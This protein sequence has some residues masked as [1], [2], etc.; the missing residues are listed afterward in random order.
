[1]TTPTRTW[2]D[3][4]VGVAIIRP[5]IAYFA[6]LALGVWVWS[7][8]D[9]L[10]QGDD[11][12]RAA[13]KAAGVF[14]GLGIAW[15]TAIAILLAPAMV[16]TIELVHRFGSETRT[17]RAA[18][19]AAIWAGWCLF[20]AIV[21][22]LTSR[23]VVDPGALVGALAVFGASGAA[24][25]FLAFDRRPPRPGIVLVSLAVAVIMLV[26]VGGFLMAGRWGSTA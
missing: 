19:G 26:V 15:L 9:H 23:V 13:V 17:S 20:V 25:S 2:G 3:R 18:I 10:R 1:M 5:L 14:V 12:I 8:I 22:A 7:T 21:L 4:V 24:Y 16:A 11:P 6:T